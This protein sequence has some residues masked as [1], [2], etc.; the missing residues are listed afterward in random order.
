[1]DE[2]DKEYRKIFEETTTRNVRAAIKF[3]NDTRALTHALEERV[4]KAENQTRLL[5]EQLEQFRVM[6]A[7]VQSKL[8]SGGT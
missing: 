4:A 5:T 2:T 1:M 7:S 3:S 8:F 6:L